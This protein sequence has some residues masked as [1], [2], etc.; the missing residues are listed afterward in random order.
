MLFV[1]LEV[2]LYISCPF[3]FQQ[4]INLFAEMFC[5]L[6][7]LFL[8]LHS[9]LKKSSLIG[10]KNKKQGKKQ[11]NNNYNVLNRIFKFC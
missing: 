7:I 8:Y 6:E 9:L 11:S 1:L 2:N 5:G 4:V 10:W 3:R